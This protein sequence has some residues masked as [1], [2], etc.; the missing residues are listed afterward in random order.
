MSGD[1]LSDQLY[2]VNELLHDVEVRDIDR[3]DA[4]A[5]EDG[6]RGGEHAQKAR[7]HGVEDGRSSAGVGRGREDDAHVDGGGLCVLVWV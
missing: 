7:E 1:A 2:L 3:R 6:G 4:D 5:E